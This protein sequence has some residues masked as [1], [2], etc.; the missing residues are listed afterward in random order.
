MF[1]K[2]PAPVTLQTTFQ[3]SPVDTPA[4]AVPVYPAICGA[5]NSPKGYCQSGI[6][7]A[8][9]CHAFQTDSR[10]W[11]KTK[12]TCRLV[13][14]PAPSP[15]LHAVILDMFKHFV[16]EHQVKVSFTNGK[17]SP[18]PQITRSVFDLASRVRSNS[19]SSPTVI[20]PLPP[21]CP[22]MLPHRSHPPGCYP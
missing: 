13:S 17:Y 7:P 14:A 19:I 6:F 5:D 15:R 18:A 2:P 21:V 10:G 8:S 11:G 1:E 3:V 16:V 22:G 9:T 4:H 12:P 20:Y